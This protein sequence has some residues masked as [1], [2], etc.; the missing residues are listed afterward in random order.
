VFHRV[1]KYSPHAFTVRFSIVRLRAV[2]CS[3]VW[4]NPEPALPSRFTPDA[5]TST[6][7]SPASM[8]MTNAPLWDW[9]AGDIDSSR[10]RVGTGIF[11]QRGPDRANH[12]DPPQQITPAAQTRKVGPD[13]CVEA[14]WPTD[15]S[16]HR[17]SPA[18]HPSRL[19]ALPLAPQDDAVLVA[20][21]LRCAHLRASKGDGQLNACAA[22][23]RA[24]SLRS[25]A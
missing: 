3:R 23:A 21:T 2:D 20:V 10:V 7:S 25:Q 4:F 1:P 5:A 6:A 17:S 9:T 8:T 11:S 18:F 13:R 14:V 24:E 22:R 19:G 12:V 15:P 16:S